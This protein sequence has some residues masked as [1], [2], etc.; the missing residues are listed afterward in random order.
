MAIIEGVELWWV[1]CDPKNPVK[2]PE[3]GKP[4]HWEVNL[5]TTDKEL[6]MYWAKNNVR[7]KPLRRKVK[8]D[9]GE[10]V[11][12]DLG[13]PVRELVKDDN[14]KPY[15]A[16]TLRKK[17]RKANGEDS[18]PVKIL[19]GMN[20]LDP[21][22]IGNKSIGNVRVFQYDYT[23]QGKDGIASMLM[24]I[25]VTK[26]LEYKPEEGESFKSVEMEVVPAADGD[27]TPSAKSQSKPN[28]GSGKAKQKEE[29]DFDED[30][31]DD[32]PFN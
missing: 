11:M 3:A 7:F 12:D 30:L 25:Q 10:F 21:K 8:G 14:G 28:K 2:N 24:A 31:D 26:L 16:V 13:E 32:I 6:A 5:R 18:E 29:S 20:D 27:T 17:V 23:Y 19:G 15:F 1:K 9:D 4:D 22:T